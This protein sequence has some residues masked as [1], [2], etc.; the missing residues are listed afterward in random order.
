[1]DNS[2][3]A[4]SDIGRIADI[5][6]LG[7]AIENIGR[8]VLVTGTIKGNNPLLS[9]ANIFLALPIINKACILCL[10]SIATL[11]IKRPALLVEESTGLIFNSVLQ[12]VSP[13][14]ET[15]LGNSGTLC[16]TVSATKGQTDARFKTHPHRRAPCVGSTRTRHDI[17]TAMGGHCGW[18]SAR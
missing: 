9:H 5:F 4:P 10:S 17:P 18:P 6:S 12:D 15:I 8:G 13:T 11:D 3:L 1:V 2:G 16:K 7:Q 14:D